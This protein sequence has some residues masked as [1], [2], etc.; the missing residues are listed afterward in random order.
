VLLVITIIFKYKQIT[1]ERLIKHFTLFLLF[2]FVF[3]FK[4]FIYL[5]VPYLIFSLPSLNDL[6]I[7]YG[8]NKR[9]I[10]L[11]S[12]PGARKKRKSIGA[13]FNEI[14]DDIKDHEY[15]AKVDKVQKFY[16]RPGCDPLYKI[17]ILKSAISSVQK[18]TGME[19]YSISAVICLKEENFQDSIQSHK[20][21]HR[22]FMGFP[23]KGWNAG[24]I[25][26]NSYMPAIGGMIED[27]KLVCEFLNAKLLAYKNLVKN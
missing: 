3:L 19:E 1:E 24:T 16:S 4:P 7:F 9:S 11:E 15:I 22:D 18:A 13:G 10:D 12:I 27:K 17:E 5:I 26:D 14:L 20:I 25:Y 21:S 6:F 8:N 23:H 2:I